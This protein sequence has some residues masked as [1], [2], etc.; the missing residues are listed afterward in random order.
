MLDPKTLKAATEGL[1]VADAILDLV[2]RFLDAVLAEDE[3]AAVEVA[4]EAIRR[5]RWERKQRE[6]KPKPKP[7]G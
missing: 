6:K 3:E 2:N 4:E 7:A 5:Q 1:E